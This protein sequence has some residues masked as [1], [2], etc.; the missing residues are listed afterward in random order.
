MDKL[1][2]ISRQ[3]GY[4]LCAETLQV[5]YDNARAVNALLA[6]LKLPNKSAV[7]LGAENGN[8]A[9]ADYRYLYAVTMGNRRLVRYTTGA[10]VSMFD[11]SAA[12]VTITETD[13]SIFDNNGVEIA[14]VYR[15]ERAVI[16]NTNVEAEKWKFYTLKEVL[17]PAIYTDL[18]PE[19]RAQ[20]ANTGVELDES[21]G[22]IL[23]KNDNK[24]RI[25]LKLVRD[26]SSHPQR[27]VADTIWNINAAINFGIN[28]SCPINAIMNANDSWWSID[29]NL[30]N[31][32][33]QLRLGQGYAQA[34][35]DIAAVNTYVYRYLVIINSEILL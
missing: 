4:P 12:K 19:F 34:Y 30:S 7:I 20:I 10:G 6:G 23:C 17:E 18:L 22:N 14:N 29:A 16:E 11:L 8:T 2:D 24:L 15:E 27:V 33:I 9:L 21:Y 35:E 13:R 5:L 3:G 1:L 32:G 26:Y 31:S 25:K 28:N